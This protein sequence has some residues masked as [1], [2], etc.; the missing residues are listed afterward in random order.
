[1]SEQPAGIHPADFPEGVIDAHSLEVVRSG[2]LGTLHE[3]ACFPLLEP[4]L[5]VF[6]ELGGLEV[7]I[8][9]GG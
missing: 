6:A 7:R 4:G 1:M 3:Q 2:Y 9:G 8:F 5:D